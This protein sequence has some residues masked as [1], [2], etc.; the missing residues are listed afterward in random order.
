MEGRI[1]T[2]KLTADLNNLTTSELYSLIL[3]AL[4]KLKDSKEYSTLSELV[5]VLDKD[6]L[7]KFLEYFGGITLTVPTLQEFKTMLH[8]LL[9]YQAVTFEHADLEVALTSLDLN[10]IDV[11]N[12][13][14]VYFKLI[15]L[16][17]DYSFQGI[18]D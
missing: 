16:L 17:R 1:L 11:N 14:K 2:S 5:Y 13:K 4:Y 8:A 10:T 18:P 7:L 6:S 15:E 9:V 3:F 12:V